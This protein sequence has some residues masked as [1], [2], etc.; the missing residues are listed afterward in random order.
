MSAFPRMAEIVPEGQR[1]GARVYH[2][3]FDATSA[4]SASY[5]G[6]RYVSTPPGTY[7]SLLV[8][9]ESGHPECMMSDL[10]YERSTCLE[11]VRRAHGEVLI[12]GLGLGMILH[13]I[14]MKPDVRRV[15]VVE[16]YRDVVDL[17]APTLPETDRLAI[18]IADI[19]AWRP[20]RASRY[21]VVWFDI[22]PDVAPTRLAEMARLH[23]RFSRYLNR[24][25]PGCWMDSWHRDETRRL[26]A[27]PSVAIR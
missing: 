21:D 12:A 5:V 8:T 16:K 9:T 11:V 1:G 23:R 10:G 18:I 17:I 22:W 15:T 24:R 6:G 19:F 4:A 26:S 14:L 7:A 20:P 13:P 25:D 27:A 2:T 3:T